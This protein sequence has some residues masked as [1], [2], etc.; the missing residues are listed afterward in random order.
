MNVTD[1]QMLLIVA[2]FLALLF[3]SIKKLADD[4]ARS[5]KKV[6]ERCKE[7]RRLRWV[8]QEMEVSFYGDKDTPDDYYPDEEDS[9]PID[10]YTDP[11][12]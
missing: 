7:I 2:F 3:F 6:D 4:L 11:P 12:F 8:I 10:W 9:I 5:R 1:R